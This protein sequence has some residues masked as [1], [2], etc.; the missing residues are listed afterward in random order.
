MYL[1]S[2]TQSFHFKSLPQVVLAWLALTERP[3]PIFGCRRLKNCSH[4][5]IKI[6]SK[7]PMLTRSRVRL[8]TM[9][10]CS[11]FHLLTH[12]S[13]YGPWSSVKDGCAVYWRPDQ[14]RYATADFLLC[15]VR[16]RYPWTSAAGAKQFVYRI[17]PG[18]FRFLFSDCRIGSR[19]A[20][21]YFYRVRFRSHFS[22]EWIRIRS[23]LGESSICPW[24][25]GSRWPL[26]WNISNAGS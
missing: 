26:V 1:K 19:P 21:Y 5:R 11:L 3:T 16:L 12:I 14:P 2:E 8:Q 6:S 13:K 15:R 17:E 7:K 18:A 10:F 20:G 24:R 25:C 22:L 9:K 23:W 4:N